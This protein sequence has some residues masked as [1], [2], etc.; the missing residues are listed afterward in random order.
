M[1]V[2]EVAVVVIKNNHKIIKER[3]KEGRRAQGQWERESDN[4]CC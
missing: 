3:E 4:Q 2:V 1:I